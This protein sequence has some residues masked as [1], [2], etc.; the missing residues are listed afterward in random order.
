MV[1][2]RDFDTLTVRVSD[3]DRIEYI[4]L[5][6]KYLESIMRLSQTPEGVEN[7]WIAQWNESGGILRD[8]PSLPVTESAQEEGPSLLATKVETNEEGTFLGDEDEDEEEDGDEEEAVDEEEFVE[9]L[10]DFLE[11]D[12]PLLQEKKRCHR[13]TCARR[14][15]R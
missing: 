15:R 6:R 11:E 7:K 1:F 2:Q 4:V 3:I 12:D 14:T 8:E 5:I 13:R 9:A 10:D